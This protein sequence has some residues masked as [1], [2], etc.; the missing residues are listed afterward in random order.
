VAKG[1]K[2]LQIAECGACEWITVHSA[3]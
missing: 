1:I 2:P 3:T